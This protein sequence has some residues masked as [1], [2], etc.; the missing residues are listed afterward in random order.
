MCEPQGGRPRTEWPQVKHEVRLQRDL[1]QNKKV[2]VSTWN[3]ERTWEDN[4]PNKKGLSLTLPRWKTLLSYQED[5][6]DALRH[7]CVTKCEV[8]MSGI[9]YSPVCKKSESVFQNWS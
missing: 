8:K 7:S 4:F 5:L 1:S 9:I 6:T 3:G 2:T